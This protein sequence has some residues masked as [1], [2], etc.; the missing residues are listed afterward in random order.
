MPEPGETPELSQNATP[1]SEV[2][3]NAAVPA[4]NTVSNH[5]HGVSTNKGRNGGTLKVG[6][7]N[8]KGGGRTIKE[9]RDRCRSGIYEG[10]CVDV[11]VK[12]LSGDIMEQIDTDDEGKPIYG[13]TKNR[14]RIEAAKFLAGYAYGAPKQTLGIEGAVA[15]LSPAE[16]VAAFDAMRQNLSALAQP[17]PQHQLPPGE[18]E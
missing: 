1:D 7:D 5:S 11:M 2:L 10:R 18:P 15:V 12:I 13:Q 14:D 3:Q 8:N 17:A 4:E 16:L 6:N 9:W